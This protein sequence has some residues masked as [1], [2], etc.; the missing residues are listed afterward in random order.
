MAFYFS[1]TPVAPN[2]VVIGYRN[3]LLYLPVFVALE[4]KLFEKRG[5]VVESKQFEQT[6]D[7]L[8]AIATSRVDTSFGGV[9]LLDLTLANQRSG[10]DPKLFA[11]TQIDQQHRITCLVSKN[12]NNVTFLAEKKVGHVPGPF[13]T[14]WARATFT[15]LNISPSEFKPLSNELLLP[16]LESGSI[17]AVYLIEPGCVKAESLNYTV[18]IDEPFARY[19][20]ENSYFT[21]SVARSQI[22]AQKLGD[23]E[24]VYNEAIDFIRANPEKSRAILANYTK[25]KIEV[26]NKVAIP[27]FLK[28]SE[29]KTSKLTDSLI[30]LQSS[31][32]INGSIDSSKLAYSGSG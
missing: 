19:F 9:N 29:W 10:G 2:K 22:P 30:V 11:V 26:A 4:N 5:L 17:D 24:S 32:L 16:S 27:V 6:K 14:A 23:I 13:G 12:F 25:V 18:L 3:H 8:A 28:S 15:V 31:R 7:L 1:T 20:D 21:T